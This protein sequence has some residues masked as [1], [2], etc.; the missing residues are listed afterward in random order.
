MH[1]SFRPE[2]PLPPY[3]DDARQA[4]ILSRYADVSAALREPALLQA[5]SKNEA[6]PGDG[7]E[8]H[9]QI[10]SVVQA[11]IA[12]M[13][14][15]AW[16]AEMERA[17]QTLI[18][19]HRGRTVDLVRDILH[20]WSIQ[21]MVH[22]CGGNGD[23]ARELFRLSAAMFL[24]KLSET[25]ARVKDAEAELDGLLEKHALM[26]KSMFAGSTQTLTSFLAKAWLALLEF[27]DQMR[28]VAK[29]PELAAGAVEEL[30]RFAGVVHTLHRKAARSVRLEGESDGE[31][32]ISAGQ[33]VELRVASANFDPAR[34]DQP[35][36]LDLARRSAGHLALG[37]GLHA[38]VGTFMVRL[39]TAAV[40]PLFAGAGPVLDRSE[41]VIWTRDS[42]LA[43]PVSVPVRFEAARA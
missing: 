3:F 40:T 6:L 43:W 13:S 39:E 30:L 8:R 7:A 33:L 28:M 25:K 29:R 31:M 10:N 2:A 21:L 26:S 15:S 22:L 4:W 9:A 19:E 24:D 1:D 20:P 27:P 18:H 41:P 14:S 36:R 11:D 38:C 12:R 5:T 17:F 37:A 35:E 42:T 23:V 34:F 16:R 32:E